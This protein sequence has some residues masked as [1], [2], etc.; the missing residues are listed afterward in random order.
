M[1]HVRRLRPLAFALGLVL[2]AAASAQSPP[3]A[4]PL[5]PRARGDLAREFV[6]KWGVYV[7]RVYRID[8]RVWAD[9]MVPTFV[10]ADPANFRRALQRDT[11]E[12]AVATLTGSG[13]RLSDAQAIDLLARA[14]PQTPRPMRTGAATP[15]V[16]TL[17]SITNDLVYTPITPCRIVD[18][19][20][21]VAGAIPAEGTRSFLAIFSDYTAQGGIAGSCGSI[22]SVTAVAMSVTAVTPNGA[23]FATVYAFGTTRPLA[24]HVNYVAGAIVNNAVITRIPNPLTSSDFTIYT[25]AQSH[26]V[27]DVVGYFTPPQATPLDCVSQQT[28]VTIANGDTGVANISCPA[29]YTATGGG[30]LPPAGVSPSAMTLRYTVHRP[31]NSWATAITN[32]TGA[33]RDFTFQARCCRVPGR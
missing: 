4:A 25:F 3:A 14:E 11:F 9:R 5:E 33:S 26:Y 12:G 7:Q 29:G 28:D 27:V 21:T 10:A 31:P 23:G 8:V 22:S 6:R 13:H 20:N 15:G 1:P 24:A 17:G 32:S 2:A 18:T 16:K 30:V 19:R